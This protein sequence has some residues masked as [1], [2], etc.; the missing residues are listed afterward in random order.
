MVRHRRV[1]LVLF[2]GAVVG[3]CGFDGVAVR[4]DAV[5]GGTPDGSADRV[6][7]PEPDAAVDSAALTPA[8]AVDQVSCQGIC[9]TAAD[10]EKCAG[11]RYLCGPTRICAAGCASCTDLARVAMPIECIACDD[12]QSNPLGTCGYDNATGFCLSG[13]YS[14]AY[15]GGAGAH[16]D[17]NDTKVANCLGRSQVCL[18]NGGTDACVTCGETGQGTNGLPCKGGGKCNAALSPPRCM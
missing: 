5:D 7:P 18:Q 11:A 16:C 2:A 1:L 17:C 8:C 13:D 3:A 15:R 10:C 14:R 12:N 4:S 9:V 6:V